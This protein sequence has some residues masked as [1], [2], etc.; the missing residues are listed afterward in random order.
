MLAYICCT[1]NKFIRQTSVIYLTLIIVLRMMAMPLS[2]LDY[3]LHK[4]YI[5]DHLCE[6]RSRPDLHCAGT[7]YLHKQ[8]NKASEGPESRNQ[9]GNAKIPVIDFLETQSIFCPHLTIA[10]SIYRIDIF[11]DGTTSPF[12]ASIFHPPIA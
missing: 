5:A 1:M 6:N 9:K 8:L 4:D 12:N 10:L 11:A 3:S 7:C 2:L